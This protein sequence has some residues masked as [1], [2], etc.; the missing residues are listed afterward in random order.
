MGWLGALSRIGA[1]GVW[2][3]LVGALAVRL[4]QARRRRRR[5]DEL[6]NEAV[7]GKRIAEAVPETRFED[8]DEAHQGGA[9]FD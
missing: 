6:A 1:I 9:R 4:L 3:L 8:R 2:S 5:G 7:A